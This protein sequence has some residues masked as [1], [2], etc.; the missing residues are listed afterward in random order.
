MSRNRFCLLSTPYPPNIEE[1]WQ[2]HSVSDAP[3]PFH[4]KASPVS[5]SNLDRD[6]L[7]RCLNRSPDAWKDFSDRFLGL[8]LHVVNQTSTSRNLQITPESRDDLVAEVFL[9]LLDR[10]FATLRRFR[11]QSS[12]ATY[13]TVVARRIIIRR[14]AQLRIPASLSDQDL[15][16]LES[17]SPQSLSMETLSLDD[18]ET[19]ENSLQKLSNDEARAIR[20]FHL[21]G[22]SYQEISSETG[23][24][25]HSLGPFLS[26]AR[27]K[28]R[29]QS[30]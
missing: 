27:E 22:R 13:L 24:P 12:L 16:S 17:P 25:P 10:D 2:D 20:M 14:L 19:L 18:R 7:E 29:L 30:E 23:I 1:I 11:G 3:I 5:L 9:C 4:P 8:I 21:E 26:R 6:L 15:A 28:M